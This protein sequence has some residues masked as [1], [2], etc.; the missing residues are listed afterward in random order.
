MHVMPKSCEIQIL[1]LDAIHCANV[2][3]LTLFPV[4]VHSFSPDDD[5]RKRQELS[6]KQQQNLK[7]LID[8]F[9]L[10]GKLYAN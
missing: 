1:R 7:D 8:K 3:L 5:H 10:G 2:F 4:Y 9:T 6:K